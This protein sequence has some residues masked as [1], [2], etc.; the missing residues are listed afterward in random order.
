MINKTTKMKKRLCPKKHNLF[1]ENG[2]QIEIRTT[3]ATCYLR[4]PSIYNTTLL[5]I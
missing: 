4:K 1:F 3:F 5:S 2:K